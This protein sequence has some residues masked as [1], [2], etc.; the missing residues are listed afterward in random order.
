MEP[1]EGAGVVPSPLGG[2]GATQLGLEVSSEGV[3]GTKTQPL[4]M[5]EVVVLLYLLLGSPFTE[6]EEGAGMALWGRRGA[7]PFMEGTGEPTGTPVEQGLPQGVEAVLASRMASP[8]ALALV[9][10]FGSGSEV[11][12]R[13]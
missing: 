9:G 3:T 5:V 10:K 6:E 2:W 12:R 1:R 8:P 4:T 13:R 7:Y 11:D